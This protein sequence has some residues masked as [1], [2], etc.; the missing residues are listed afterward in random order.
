MVRIIP[1]MISVGM[2]CK[3]DADVVP[4]FEA[5]LMTCR[6]LPDGLLAVSILRTGIL[7]LKIGVEFFEYIEHRLV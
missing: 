6:M 4:K 3:T 1:L 5:T 2:G 7:E